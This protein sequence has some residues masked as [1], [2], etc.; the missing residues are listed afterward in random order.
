MYTVDRIESLNFKFE[1]YNF[2][3]ISKSKNKRQYVDPI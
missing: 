1:I 2:A 3:F